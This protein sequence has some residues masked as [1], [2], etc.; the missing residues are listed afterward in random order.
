MSDKKTSI[1]TGISV[2][3]LVV[4]PTAAGAQVVTP[5]V[6]VAENKQVD[7]SEIVVTANK[8]EQSIKDVGM[9]IQAAS[10][11]TLAARGI[12][13][14]NDLGKLVSGFTYT[15]SLYTTPVYTL[16]GIGLY[17][18]TF[19]AVPAVAVYTDQ[20]PRNFPVMSDALDLDLE[21]IEVLKGPQGTLFGQSATG[22]AVNYITAKPTNRLQAGVDGSFERFNKAKL[23][24]FVSGPLSSTLK[25]RIA[26]RAIEGGDWQYSLSRPD[27]KNGNVSRIEGRGSLDWEPTPSVRI[28]ANLTGALDRSD[29]QAPQY[30]KTNL[31]IYSSAALAAANANPATT[32]PYGVVDNVLY[33]GLTTPGSSNFDNSF[34]SRQNTLVTRMNSTNPALV[35][36]NYPFFSRAILGTPAQPNSSRAAEWSVGTHGPSDNQYLQA[37]LRSD[38]NI[39]DD[40]ALTLISAYAKKTLKY[41][42]D[43][44]GT[45]AVLQNIPLT[46]R[47]RTFNQE[48]R[49]AGK[50]AKFRWMVGLNYDNAK[51]FQENDFAT[52]HY[53]ANDPL[54]TGDPAQFIHTNRN[55]FKSKLETFGAFANAEY[56]IT[57]NLKLNAGIRYTKNKQS[58]SYCYHDPGEKVG[59]PGNVPATTAALFNFLQ[60][61]FSGLPA[62]SLPFIRPND[63]FP[64]GNGLKGTTN[65]VA[66]IK[67]FVDSLTESNVSFRVGLDYK[68]SGGTLLYA[69]VSQGYKAGLFSA[70]GAAN[71][72]QYTPA[73]Q[74]K[75][76]AYEAGFKAPIIDRVFD[77][78]GAAFYYD[79]RNKQ[80]RGRVLDRL[81]GLLEKMLNVPKSYIWGVEADARIRP[82]DGLTLTGSGTYLKSKVTSSFSTTPDGLAVY[83]TGGYTGDFKGSE[84]PYT[85]K[86]SA[87]ADINYEW[88]MGEVTPFVGGGI[89]YQGKQ[90]GTFFNNVLKASDFEIK[91]YS[92]VDLRAGV[93]AKDGSWQVTVYGRNV[94]NKVYTTS[95]TT[96]LDAQFRFTGRP[97]VYGLSAKFRLK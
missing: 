49:L 74:E 52:L 22:G 83:N 96:F 95:V 19:G 28:Q 94:F 46:G 33:A 56:N 3:A 51:T 89:T 75:V 50:S 63:C 8:R 57:S 90:N 47:V 80:V 40:V 4:L 88:S 15:E 82:V 59:V 5:T 39:T 26:V 29:I 7:E 48:I 87:N 64:F 92:T 37:S 13:S 24:G 68:L 81:F 93:G 70:I 18:A 65:N 67:P 97:A 42:I 85:P 17:D 41:T 44:D 9:T 32:N 58:A 20:V 34:L 84:L 35:A 53:A 72:G 27:D 43:L 25:G 54:G 38:I 60:P 71:T 10:A 16:R 73:V 23:S 79:Y 76:L 6:K 55:T 91:G 11:E 12:E 2:M 30:I 1:L 45:V 36:E 69:T 21:R 77:L 61:I 66:I 86:F 31:N 62:A 78:N 14:L